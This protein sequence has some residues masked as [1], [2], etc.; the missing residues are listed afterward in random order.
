MT[1]QINFFCVFVSPYALCQNF[2]KLT[3][4]KTWKNLLEYINI[5]FWLAALRKTQYLHATGLRHVDYLPNLLC[6]L[7]Q[8]EKKWWYNT[9]ELLC[10]NA[11][12]TP[13]TT[14]R[15]KQAAV[16]HRWVWVLY[17]YKCLHEETMKVFSLWIPVVVCGS[18]QSCMGFSTEQ[19]IT[20]FVL[21]LKNTG[22]QSCKVKTDSL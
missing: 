13:E 17:L 1:V 3:G 16:L 14:L 5:V 21:S 9:L 2:T 7:I 19:N 10:G 20:G 22:L 11:A 8:K 15:W 6:F 18:I 4:F 12:F